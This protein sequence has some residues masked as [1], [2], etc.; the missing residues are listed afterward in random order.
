M[1]IHLFID[2]CFFTD[3]IENKLN[4]ALKKWEDFENELEKH[5]AWLRSM[6]AS[7]RDQRLQST[8]EEKE[9]QLQA[10]KDKRDLITKQEMEIDQF[11]DRSHGLI[12]TSHVERIKSLVSQ[13]S[14]R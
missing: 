9:N 6:E 13:I 11:I 2:Y 8:L 7:F 14:N 5:T 3:S 4:A 1:I 12:N 10:F